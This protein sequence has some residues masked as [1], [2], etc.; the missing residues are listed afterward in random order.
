MSCRSWRSPT[1]IHSIDGSDYLFSLCGDVTKNCHSAE[2]GGKGASR[3]P[4]GPA[5]LVKLDGDGH[6]TATTAGS[7]AGPDSDPVFNPA[8]GTDLRYGAF[9]L[10]LQDYVDGTGYDL[11]AAAS[12]SGAPRNLIG[13][14]S[15]FSDPL[16]VCA[17]APPF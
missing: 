2:G 16:V 9:S 14:S 15:V 10:Q 12:A 8:T 6:C 13:G 5:S 17:P 1:T 3:G 11:S 4:T 7:G